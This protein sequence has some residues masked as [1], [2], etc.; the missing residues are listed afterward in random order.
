MRNPVNSK[1]IIIFRHNI[2]LF[3]R[4]TPV[5][6]D[7]ALKRGKKNIYLHDVLLIS[8]HIFQYS[9]LRHNLLFIYVLGQNAAGKQDDF[10]RV[11]KG[12]CMQRYNKTK[13]G[14]YTSW[15]AWPGIINAP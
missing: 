13:L 10:R 7:L 4:I 1:D 9:T 14:D 6:N 12:G 11:S 2:I 3:I 5:G 15:F 8:V